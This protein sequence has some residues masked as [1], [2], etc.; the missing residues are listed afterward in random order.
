MPDDE[1]QERFIQL[2]AAV[3]KWVSTYFG[4]SKFTATPIP[5]AI[6]TLKK[7]FPQYASLIKENTK[8]TTILEGLVVDIIS[9]SFTSGQLLG[10]EA[11]WELR[12]SITSTGKYEYYTYTL[13]D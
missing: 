2:R 7:T 12:Q 3:S 11:F 4:T 13:N 9:Q 5:D 8:V 1:I 10:N 6:A